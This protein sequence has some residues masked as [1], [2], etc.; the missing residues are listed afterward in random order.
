MLPQSGEADFVLERHYISDQQP[1]RPITLGIV[2]LEHVLADAGL[3]ATEEATGV[4]VA[5]EY[6][7]KNNFICT[8]GAS[9]RLQI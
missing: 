3:S 2:A 1:E 5:S 7:S 8:L 6:D 4:A 9:K